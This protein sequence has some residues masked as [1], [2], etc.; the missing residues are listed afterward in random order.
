MEATVDP[1][2]SPA[3][4]AAIAVVSAVAIVVIHVIVGACHLLLGGVRGLLGGRGWLSLQPEDVV[5]GSCL[6]EAGEAGVDVRSVDLLCPKWGYVAGLERKVGCEDL[7][8]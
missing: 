1:F 7:S 4:I 8:W 5:L 6:A 3:T 2:V